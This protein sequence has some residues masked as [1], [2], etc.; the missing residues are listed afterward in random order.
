VPLALVT[1]SAA[2]AQALPIRELGV[3][4]LLTASDPA[5]GGGGMYAALRPSPRM[6]LAATASVG[7]LGGVAAFRGELLGHFL[8]N[9]VARR[10]TGFYLGGGAAIVAGADTRGYL[11][12]LVGLEAR[13][14]DRSGWFI[15]GGVGGG[16]RL[17]AGWRLRW[18]R[19]A[20]R[21]K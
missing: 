15:E 20:R 9:P 7:A 13:P 16:A 10:G 4:G 18:V 17:A 1:P 5:F 6:R 3:Q 12:A 2:P 19:R 8:L 21:P 11:V 14:A